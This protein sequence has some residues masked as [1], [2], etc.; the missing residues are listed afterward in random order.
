VDKKERFEMNTH[1][2]NLIEGV[3]VDSAVEAHLHEC[4]Y[5]GR[6][7]TRKEKP[8]PEQVYNML[9]DEMAKN[10]HGLLL[11][12]ERYW[13]P[14]LDGFFGVEFFDTLLQ[15]GEG[16]EVS[17][18]EVAEAFLLPEGVVERILWIVC[19]EGPVY[20]ST[21][22]SGEEKWGFAELPIENCVQETMCSTIVPHDFE[23]DH[24]K[25]KWGH[26]PS[27]LSQSA[28]LYKKVIG[29]GSELFF[30]TTQCL[31]PEDLSMRF[32]VSTGNA[33]IALDNL[34]L[35]GHCEK[36]PQ[37]EDRYLFNASV[38][39]SLPAFDFESDKELSHM[40]ATMKKKR[41]ER[42]IVASYAEAWD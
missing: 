20:P 12:M 35:L 14:S 36:D 25:G 7:R 37:S 26:L 3:R 33:K 42:A 10:A 4:Y 31:T 24:L 11:N 28:A 27:C 6:G 1:V 2:R 5:E 15:W 13:D 9:V 41:E 38:N 21:S 39:E 17:T 18:K 22:D 23:Y 30:D 16:R 8:T 32:G 34:E 40:I 19:E 29:W